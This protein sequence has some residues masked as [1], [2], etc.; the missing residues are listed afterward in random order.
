MILDHKL[1]PRFLYLY[2]ITI[3]KVVII[4][5]KGLKCSL[6]QTCSIKKGLKCSLIK[7]CSLRNA[8]RILFCWPRS[9]RCYGRFSSAREPKQ[10]ILT[11]QKIYMK[12]NQITK[13]WLKYMLTQQQNLKH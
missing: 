4:S 6:I 2:I 11:R 1:V 7:T 10:D 3:L 8:L 5:K 13:I 9:Q 12:N